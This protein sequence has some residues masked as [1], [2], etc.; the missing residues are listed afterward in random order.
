M[1][2]MICGEK[3]IEESVESALANVTD[4]ANPH[5]A[6]RIHRRRLPKGM[7]IPRIPNCELIA[8]DIVVCH[9]SNVAAANN[10]THS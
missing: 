6:M 7:S 9:C 5:D 2:G 1:G 8:K 3:N 10:P 4:V